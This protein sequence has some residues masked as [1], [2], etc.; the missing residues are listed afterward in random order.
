MM[1]SCCVF[2]TIFFVCCLFEESIGSCPGRP[3]WIWPCP[4]SRKSYEGNLPEITL[5]IDIEDPKPQCKEGGPC[6]RHADCGDFGE[7]VPNRNDK[8]DV[9]YP[10][11]HGY[12]TSR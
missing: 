12:S 4:N 2:V 8:S 6:L 5:N 7:C 1:K 10:V 11:G 3:P 9:K